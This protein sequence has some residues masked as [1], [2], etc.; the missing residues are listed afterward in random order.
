[1]ARLILDTNTFAYNNKY[2]RQIRGGAMGSAF[3]QVLANIYTFEWKQDLIKH[4]EKHNEI[5]GRYI[6]IF[7]TTNQTIDEIREQLEKAQNQDVNIKINYNID[8]SV[9]FLDASAEPYILP[10]RSTHPRHIHRNIPYGALL[11][12]VRICSNMHDFNTERCHIDVFLLLNGYPPNF[13]TK[14]FHRLLH[15]KNTMLLLKQM[16]EQAYN[17]IYET[18]LHQHTGREKELKKMIKDPVK[19]PLVLQS[20]IWDSKLMYPN[21]LF[22]SGQSVDT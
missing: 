9:D 12:A 11:R 3:T 21:Y 7:M 4:Q 14:Q 20:K 22:D 19:K 1:M 5:Y 8:I 15:S 13:I 2:Y 10:Y 18:L 16:N 17:P 6:D